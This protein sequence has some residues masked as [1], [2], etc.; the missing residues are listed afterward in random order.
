MKKILKFFRTKPQKSNLYLGEAFLDPPVWVQCPLCFLDPV[1]TSMVAPSN[2][3]I[4]V[5]H[6]LGASCLNCELLKGREYGSYFCIYYIEGIQLLFAEW[7]TKWISKKINR[8][9]LLT[10]VFIKYKRRQHLISYNWE[11]RHIHRIVNKKMYDKFLT[12]WFH[13]QRDRSQK[14]ETLCS[15]AQLNF[16]GGTEWECS[17]QMS[18]DEANDT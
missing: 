2:S 13:P 17:K 15:S 1:H 12:V 3:I 5:T 11:R 8:W 10:W 16:K 6:L 9:I 7:M 14:M 4:I 18:Q